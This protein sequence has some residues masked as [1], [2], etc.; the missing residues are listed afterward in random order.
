MVPS[1]LFTL[2]LFPFHP[3]FTPVFVSDGKV[4]KCAWS[5]IS[6]AMQEAKKGTRG[7]GVLLRPLGLREGDFEDKDGYH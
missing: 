5:R 7:Q 3:T 2:P 4:G 6:S 1:C